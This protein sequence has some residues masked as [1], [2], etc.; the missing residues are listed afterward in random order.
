[1][2]L[3]NIINLRPQVNARAIQSNKVNFASIFV[4]SIPELGSFSQYLV[5][6]TSL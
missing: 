2:G 4:A 6:K 5:P 3:R 1:M